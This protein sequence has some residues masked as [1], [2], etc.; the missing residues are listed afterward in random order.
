[1]VPLSSVCACSIACFLWFVNSCNKLCWGVNLLF[2]HYLLTL[3]LRLWRH[4]VVSLFGFWL[5]LRV[6]VALLEARSLAGK[7]I[8]IGVFECTEGFLS[9]YCIWGIGLLCFSFYIPP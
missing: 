7:F 9:G 6:L 2:R 8:D 4:R 3:N 5:T 1:M